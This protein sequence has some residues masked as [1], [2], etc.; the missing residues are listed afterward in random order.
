M[1]DFSK[2]EPRELVGSV[3]TFAGLLHDDGFH[4]SAACVR[5][6]ADR[7]IRCLDAG[8]LPGATE[9]SQQAMLPGQ[10][11][12]VRHELSMMQRRHPKASR[13]RCVGLLEREYLQRLDALN[14]LFVAETPGTQLGAIRLYQP[15]DTWCSVTDDM[16]PVGDAVL[17]RGERWNTVDVAVLRTDDDG[18]HDRW[19][20]SSPSDED[21]VYSL[22]DVTHW[23]P[24]PKAPERG[25]QP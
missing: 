10:D 23:M 1:R 6:L 2:L 24:I 19:E 17:I 14:A 3:L 21:T 11:A 5:E 7:V 9:T 13:A 8:V 22:A 20:V 12:A 25:T 16:P 18:S 4:A 15:A